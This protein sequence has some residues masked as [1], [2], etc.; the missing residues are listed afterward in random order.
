MLGSGTDVARLPF[1]PAG[2]LTMRDSNKPGDMGEAVVTHREGL[3]HAAVFFLGA[4]A[5]LSAR[6]ARAES[7]AL[8]EPAPPLLNIIGRI[9]YIIYID[10]VRL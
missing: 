6:V 5:F 2:K 10:Y 1:L 3:K 4:P 8:V 9:M 7:S